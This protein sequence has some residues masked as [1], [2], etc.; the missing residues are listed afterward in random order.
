MDV[1]IGHVFD[2]QHI[3]KR[4]NIQT[5]ETKKQRKYAE[6]YQQQSSAFAPM[7]ANTL[8]HCR[9]NVV[10]TVYNSNGF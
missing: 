4:R 9:G 3:F 7:V 1:T 10:L 6:H 5:M 2:M 8:G